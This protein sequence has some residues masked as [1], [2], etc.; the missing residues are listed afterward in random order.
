MGESFGVV[1]GEVAVVTFNRPVNILSS[2]V[3]RDLVGT[4]DALKESAKVLVF[5]GEGTTFVAGADIKE[6]YGFGENE[7][8]SFAR[9]IHSAFNAVEAFP[10]PVIAG[11]NG[12]ALGGGCELALACD[13]VVASESAIF[14]MPEINLGI[15]PGGGGTK[16]LAE[17]VGKMKAKELILTGR[18]VGA[19]E[20][21]SIGLVNKVVP[22]GRLKD[23][24]LSLASTIAHKPVQCLRAAKRLIESAS[25]EEEIGVWTGLFSFEDRKRLMGEFLE[26]KKR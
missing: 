23:E 3:L 16:R 13:I 24:V 11:V 22:R 18:R 20:A 1:P 4:L 25:F 6:M 10:V 5:F 15:V 14:G 12:F 17:R 26:R 8:R 2:G 19:D 7:A 9:L 21:L